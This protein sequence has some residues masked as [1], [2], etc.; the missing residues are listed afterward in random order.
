MVVDVHTWRYVYCSGSCNNNSSYLNE[1]Q[2]KTCVVLSEGKGLQT[3]ICGMWEGRRWESYS[4][5]LK[6]NTE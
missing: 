2:N 4:F 1:Y 6:V 3:S 5:V